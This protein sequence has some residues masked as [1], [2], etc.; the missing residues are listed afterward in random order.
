MLVGV[1]ERGFHTNDDYGMSSLASGAFTGHP[2]GRLVYVNPLVGYP[3]SWLYRLVPSMPWYALSYYVVHCL[4]LAAIADVLVRRRRELGQ[5][6]TITTA[7]VVFAVAP[8][9]LL[10]LSFTTTAFMA[11]LAGV[12]LTVDICLEPRWR[13]HL[14]RAATAALLI[15][16][17]LSIRQ[18]AALAVLLV[19]SPLLAVVSF[20]RPRVG[21]SLTGLAL[22]VWALNRLVVCFILDANYRSFLA[23]NQLRGGLHGTP[24]ISA[25]ALTPNLLSQIGWTSTDR[26]MFAYF[27]FDDRSLFGF[28]SLQIITNNTSAVRK[29]FTR[30]LVVDGILTRYPWLLCAFALT[31]VL[32]I[33][34]RKW[35]GL[36]AGA[37]GT[38]A[39][40]AMVWM[41][42]TSRIPERTVLPIWVTLCVVAALS[43]ALSTPRALFI[44]VWIDRRVERLSA[45]IVAFVLV[46][47]FWTGLIGPGATSWNPIW[48]TLCVVAALSAALST[49]RALVIPVWIDRWVGSLSAAVIA[50]VLVVSVWTGPIGP[51]ATSSHNL[52]RRGL[53]ADSLDTI[54]AEAG[55]DIVV[56][57]AGALPT[58]GIDPLSVTG[59]YSNERLLGLGW[60]TF[61]PMFEERKANAGIDDTLRS[62]LVRDDVVWV[63]NRKVTGYYQRFLVREAGL[64]KGPVLVAAACDKSEHICIWR[65]AGVHDG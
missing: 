44:P 52:F 29:P 17:A 15:T 59:P 4:A 56:A 14:M 3:I 41:G 50:S 7:A 18:N 16:V 65:K 24:R 1:S 34:T 43:A 62:I 32:V 42:M 19:S 37:G 53:L 21:L 9:F 10:Q 22:G 60:P 6:V 23:Y 30:A 47:S 48:V 25:E 39:V 58:Q 45:A 63:A 64:D 33:F 61:S 28:E 26:G 13:Q 57:Y 55:D 2:D 46:I 49:P 38:I 5:L 54:E 11:A 20:R 36:L 27:L 35:S 8:R 51:G 12:V 31:L 40:A